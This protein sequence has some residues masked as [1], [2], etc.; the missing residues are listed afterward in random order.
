LR[1]NAAI[2]VAETHAVRLYSA[3][4]PFR[5][6]FVVISSLGYAHRA[7][8]VAVS[9]SFRRWATRIAPLTVNH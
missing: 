8:F 3:S 9:S 4:R 2:F 6:D 7:H 5:R 1:I